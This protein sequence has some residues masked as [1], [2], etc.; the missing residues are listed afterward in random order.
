MLTPA[1]N[2]ENRKHAS[3]IRGVVAIAGYL[4]DAKE[5]FV[6]ANYINDLVINYK[7]TD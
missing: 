3:I 5:S 2:D 4:L 6:D 1:E 7:R